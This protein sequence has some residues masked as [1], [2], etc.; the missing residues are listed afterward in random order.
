MISPELLR[1]YPFF[2]PFTDAEQKEIAMFAQELELP[3]GETLFEIDQPAEHLYLLVSGGVDLY[4][5]AVDRQDNSL[6]KTFF[7]GEI[8]PGEILAF[9]SLVAPYKLTATARVSAPSRLVKFDALAL[10]QFADEHPDFA[11][12]LMHQ[13]A[14]LVIE[15]LNETR[16]LLAAATA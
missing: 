4:D 8:D 12:R 5:V 3:A 7:V 13:I 10:R 6:I 1:R 2:S 16:V 15:R 11:Y 9:S 14:R